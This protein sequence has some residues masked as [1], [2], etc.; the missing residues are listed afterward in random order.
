MSAIYTTE[1]YYTTTLSSDINSSTTTIPLTAVPARVTTGYMVIEPESATKREVIHFTSVG[2]SS[3]TSADDTTDAS[4][5]SGRGCIGSI[6]VG[7][8][9]THSQGATVIIAGV[10]QYWSRLRSNLGNILDLTTGELDLT[11][12]KSALSAADAGANDTYAITLS[13]APSA[14]AD[15]LGL[16]ISFKA[17]T[18]NTG[19]ATLNVN[20]IGAID[21]KKFGS[22]ALSDGDIKANQWVTVIYDGTNFQLQSLALPS[23]TANHFLKLVSSIPTWAFAFANIKVGSTTYD[24]SLT[25]SLAVTGVGFTPSALIAL[26][27]ISGGTNSSLSV[28][29]ASA[30]AQGTMSHDNAG[31]SWADG[32]AVGVVWITAPGTNAI[33]TLASM[34]ADGFTLTRSKN[35][36]PTGTATLIYA[37]FG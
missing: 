14:Y 2:V 10:E 26:A 31:K 17:N 35:G 28:G 15:I 21:I 36:S 9:T 18:I 1:G 37:C 13:P 16:P 24:V 6:T 29:V 7:A 34:D 20:S 11:E 27:C 33:L 5:A 8:N 32:T 19:A 23:G 12:L 30:T 3:V 22:Q 4:D 25:S